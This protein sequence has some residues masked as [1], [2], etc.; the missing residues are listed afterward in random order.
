MKYIILIKLDKIAK[1]EKEKKRDYHK[2]NYHAQ[3]VDL[4]LVVNNNFRQKQISSS[5]ARTEMRS[6]LRK[7]E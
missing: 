1:K 6:G 3:C 2:K 4:Q 5:G 7:Q